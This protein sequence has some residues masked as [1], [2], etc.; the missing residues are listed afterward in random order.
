MLVSATRSIITVTF[1]VFIGQ[2][3]LMRLQLPA[4]TSYSTLVSPCPLLSLFSFFFISCQTRPHAADL[5]YEVLAPSLH[6]YAHHRHCPY[7]PSSPQPPSPLHLLPRP[8]SSSRVPLHQLLFVLFRQFLAPPRHRALLPHL[9]YV[10]TPVFTFILS[11]LCLKV[12]SSLSQILRL[13]VFG[14]VL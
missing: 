2:P 11:A 12:C 3:R 8:V 7:A 9:C 10:I 14:S 6:S 5:P 1:A 4:S 13:F